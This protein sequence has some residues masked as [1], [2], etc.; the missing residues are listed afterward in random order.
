METIHLNDLFAFIKYD[1]INFIVW[2][3]DAIESIIPV[4]LGQYI[5]FFAAHK[6]AED[7]LNG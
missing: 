6:A 2:G 1:G 4:F 5:N 3:D 7:Y